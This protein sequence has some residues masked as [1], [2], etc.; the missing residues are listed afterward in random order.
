MNLKAM[1]GKATRQ[2][3]RGSL[4]GVRH[5]ARHQVMGLSAQF[6][7]GMAVS[8]IGLTFVAGVLTMITKN[9]W[10]SHAIAAGFIASLLLYGSLLVQAQGLVQRPEQQS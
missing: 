4:S 8:L 5:Y 10:L 9:D 7:L 1:S 2:D 3:A 6:L